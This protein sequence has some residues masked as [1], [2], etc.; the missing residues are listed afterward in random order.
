[1][2]DDTYTSNRRLNTGA[3][4]FNAISF[5]VEN[6]IKGLVNTAIPV[7]VDACTVNSQAGSMQPAGYVSVTPLVMQ[8]G[9]DGKSLQPVSIP[10]LPYFRYRAGKAALVMD[11]Q[12]GDIG[13]AVFAQ[14][15]I[16][17]LKQ[18]GTD[19]VPA[20]SFRAF[21]QSDGVYLGGILG[22]AP[23]VWVYIAPTEGKIEINA[24]KDIILKSGTKI[25]MQAPEI[26]MQGGQSV[27]TKAPQV[28][29]TSPAIAMNGPIA[30]NDVSGGT[31]GSMTVN[32][33]MRATGTLKSDTSMTAPEFYGH[34][35]GDVNGLC[36]GAH[37]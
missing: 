36:S 24:P 3:S 20:G 14:Q 21:D 23:E 8:R 18:E 5:L 9:A 27:T 4:D 7:K 19:P 30:A 28:T 34:L 16:S 15:D 32:G 10:Q 17:G 31:G 35:N 26:N 2:A 11:P 37:G 6:M 1:M 33:S 12:P 13:L 29:T 25:D 22:P